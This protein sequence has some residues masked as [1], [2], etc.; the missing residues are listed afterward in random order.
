MAKD[1]YEWLIKFNNKFLKKVLPLRN[2]ILYYYKPFI[3]ERFKHGFVYR[4]L[5]VHI[6]GKYLPTGGVNIRKWTRRKMQ[7][8]TLKGNTL[9]A[10]IEFRYKSCFFETLHLPF[11]IILLWRS[12]WWYFE[13]NNINLAIELLLVSTLF[14]IYPIMHQRYTRIRIDKLIELKN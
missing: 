7:S 5:G 8:Y 9:S 4:L 1:G 13:Y 10:A 6:F 14:N 2:L 3:F 12:L 11:L